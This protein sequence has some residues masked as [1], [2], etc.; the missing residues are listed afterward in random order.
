MHS[1]RDMMGSFFSDSKKKPGFSFNV[2]GEKSKYVMILKGGQ[3]PLL[4]GLGAS[5]QTYVHIVFF[6]VHR[7]SLS[8][9]ENVTSIQ[10]LIHDL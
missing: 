8:V 4:E 9:E 7:L 5:I 1:F 6:K 2:Y 3:H 10:D